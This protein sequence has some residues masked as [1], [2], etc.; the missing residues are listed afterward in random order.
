[1]S[2]QAKNLDTGYLC[3]NC[4]ADVETPLCARCG[5]IQ[6][7]HPQDYFTLLGLP[8]TY[9]INLDLMRENYLNLQRMM[10]PDL[11]ATK[12]SREK[13][14]A[15]QQTV[16]CN[17]AYETLK[18]PLQRGYYLL[19][20][21]GYDSGVHEE[22]TLTDP[23]LL[24]TVLMEREALET[25]T[26]LEQ[27]QQCLSTAQEKLLIYEEAIKRAFQ[28]QDLKT[29]LA[30]LRRYKY[31]QKFIEKAASRLKQMKH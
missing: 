17:Q 21:L 1:M 3:W 25:A 19:T 4:H 26:D 20:L 29:A 24:L 6:P 11:F 22:Q 5:K 15:S 7:I 23:E 30:F 14:Y 13:L 18:D 9:A 8:I 16:V 31:Q 28:E 2:S 12:P 27:I 10:H